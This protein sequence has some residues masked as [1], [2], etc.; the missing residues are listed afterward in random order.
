ML[1]MGLLWPAMAWPQAHV[2]SQNTSEVPIEQPPA[3]VLYQGYLTDHN[4]EALLDGSYEITFRLYDDEEAG[5]V[6]WTETRTIE[7][8]GGTFSLHLGQENSLEQVDFSRAR[9]LSLEL[10]G[11]TETAER[12]QL[13]AVPF[14]LMAA[15]VKDGQVVKGINGLT[16]QIEI[17]AGDG[18]SVTEGDDGR[19]I[20]SARTGLEGAVLDTNL[21]QGTSGGDDGDPEPF[22]VFNEVVRATPSNSF[23]EMGANGGLTVENTAGG[24]AN[25]NFIRSSSG[26]DQSYYRFVN[27][28]NGDFN[29]RDVQNSKSPFKMEFA[30]MENQ[31]VL[32][33]NGN[34]GIGTETPGFDLDVV[35]VIHAEND[36]VA[37]N[38]LIAGFN[39]GQGDIS[40]FHNGNNTI[41]LDGHNGRGGSIEVFDETATFAGV[42]LFNTHNDGGQIDVNDENEV[43]LVSMFA[44]SNYGV[45]QTYADDGSLLVSL[46]SGTGEGGEFF[47]QDG[48][49]TNLVRMIP[50]ALGTGAFAEF[51][52]VGGRSMIWDA[53]VGLSITGP[54]NT[55]STVALPIGSIDNTEMENEPGLANIHSSTGFGLTGGTDILLTRTITTPTSGFVFV[56]GSAQFN[57]STSSGIN[58]GISDDCDASPTL[59]SSQDFLLDDGAEGVSTLTG[60]AHGTFSVSAGSHTFCLLADDATAGG[61]ASAVD[62]QLD[63]IFFP[64]SY[65]TTQTNLPADGVLDANQPTAT[66]INLQAERTQSM[67][68][69]E[70]R[71]QVELERM[72]AQIDE[73]KAIIAEQDAFVGSPV[74]H[75]PKPKRD[76]EDQ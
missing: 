20:I 55:T 64:T 70:A 67:A 13:S 49:G 22:I 4:G 1:I 12:T 7:V 71:M 52:G 25:I 61:P 58:Y 73:L 39:G 28:A 47:L 38:D 18:I 40:V 30:A 65:G 63:V 51:T 31:L 11:E 62:R 32:A 37:Q 44:A 75:P 23:H 74:A 48:D 26:V 76:D 36:V 2:V 72:Q 33:A 53:D 69:N 46:E 15:D 41:L 3:T 35:G 50:D 59:P 29:I 43:P 66:P 21:R 34:V 9:F 5:K 24:A 42:E 16:D 14:S 8:T 19:L 56:I 27:R 54:S 17:V 57:F 45:L 6:L 60:T 68:D 10:Q